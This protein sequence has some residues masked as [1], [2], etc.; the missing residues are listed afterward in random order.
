[1]GCLVGQFFHQH[2]A[3]Q[4]EEKTCDSHAEPSPLEPGRS[5]HGPNGAS[6][7]KKRRQRAKTTRQKL[8]TRL[9]LES[10][11]SAGTETLGANKMQGEFRQMPQSAWETIYKRFSGS[12][13]AR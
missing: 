11:L 6:T 9:Q 12:G 8:W 7:S 3:G 1:M 5:V 2:S 13:P 10:N 4:L